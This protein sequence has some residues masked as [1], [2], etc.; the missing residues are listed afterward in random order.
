MSKKQSSVKEEIINSQ[1]KN[2][3]PVLDLVRDKITASVVSKIV[4]DDTYVKRVDK[5]GERELLPP[6]FIETNRISQEKMQDITDA[7]SVM[8]MLPDLELGAQILISCI[9]SPKDMQTVELIHNPPEKLFPPSVVSLM[10]NKIRDFLSNDY[11]IEP[12]LPLILR[13][14]L[15]NTGSYPVA[16]IPEN[17]I[18]E[19]INGVEKTSMESL[20]DHG[21]LEKIKGSD[22]SFIKSLGLLGSPNQNQNK[23]KLFSL[24]NYSDEFNL[25][26]K[27]YKINFSLENL[28]NSRIENNE[29]F[30]LINEENKQKRNYEDSDLFTVTDNYAALSFPFLLS[31][32]KE[33]SIYGK[34][35]SPTLENF[36]GRLSNKDIELLL[37]R[38]VDYGVN[39]VKKV[40][41]SE[42]C[43]RSSVGEPL[44]M[45]FPSESVIN[46][47][48]PGTTSESVGHFI[49]CDEN[50][51][52]ISRNS[53]VDHYRDLYNISNN[54]KN[55]MASNLIDKAKTMNY[56]YRVGDDLIRERINYAAKTYGEIIEND[57]INRLK[58]GVYGSSVKI[59]NYTEI[60][61]VMLARALKQQR[62]QLIFIPSE[63]MT[64]MA[65]NYDNNGIGYSLLD[66]LKVINSLAI[67]LLLANVRSGVMNSIPRTKVDVQLDEN[68]PDN[69][70]V[71]STVMHEYLQ[72][73][74]SGNY[75]MPLGTSDPVAITEW[76]NKAGIEFSFS[77]DP[78][79][80]DMKV[81]IS[82]YN[83]NQ[84]KADSD[85]IDELKRLRLNGI[86]LTP[87]IVDASN[88]PDFAT[89]II[90]ESLLF[91]RRTQQKQNEFIPYLSD[92]IRKLLLNSPKMIASLK[93]VIEDNF[94]SIIK[95]LL[96]ESKDEKFNL[97]DQDKEKIK[98]KL[99]KV[100]IEKY[101]VSLPKPDSLSITA[102]SDAFSVYMDSINKAIEYYISNEA[103]PEEYSGVNMQDVLGSVK[104]MVIAHFARKWM[105]ENDF[106]TELG[107]MISLNEDGE[108]QFNLLEVNKDF[109][110]K[111]IKSIGGVL[112]S[113][114]PIAKSADA[115]LSA[116]ELVNEEKS[117]TSDSDDDSGSFGD[118]DDSDDDW[119]NDDEEGDNLKENNDQD[120]K[121]D[122]NFNL[123]DDDGEPDQI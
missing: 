62:T 73:R 61:R 86:G 106:L 3:V 67:H 14:I 24:E 85:L 1:N 99:I 110:E 76:A 74:Q 119:A 13:D 70:K 44:V 25:N 17:S 69:L 118:T 12:R 71:R 54:N 39:F 32:I 36:T 18:D 31:K 20:L 4:S 11:K 2:S 52:P 53:E 43:F 102:K 8:Q 45:H 83:S 93:D 63:L 91:A 56:G 72:L 81:D 30:K 78:K 26:S 82:E 29:L 16:V 94:D 47:Y 114:K 117:E 112:E 15:F 123:D 96:P 84:P 113:A 7:E 111:M 23:K 90:Q 28:E 37:N 75:G 103:I 48:V 5:N 92:H 27:D 38:K 115:V 68:T 66:K 79:Q 89:S 65:F 105:S 10:V 88:A 19:I 59:S 60:Y 55:L 22:N 49:V 95:L 33:E 41:T 21:F 80:P 9:L 64:Y 42:Q 121:S 87:E 57:L 58:N 35:N 100:F 34:L 40:K 104:N 101:E 109:M 46:V 98:S 108:S 122:D 97:D 107:D 116:N 120:D 77:G 50:C 6:D 51:Y